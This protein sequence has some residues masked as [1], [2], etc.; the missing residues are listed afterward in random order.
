MVCVTK[1]IGIQD[2]EFQLR[3][4]KQLVSV[5]KTEQ[6]FHKEKYTDG[7]SLR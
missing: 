1:L 5:Q 3:E 2:K 7:Q 4:K 6:T